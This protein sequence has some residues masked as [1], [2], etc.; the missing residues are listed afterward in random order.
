MGARYCFT[1]SLAVRRR[2]RSVP[3][4]SSSSSCS[5]SLAPGGASLAS[6]C[7]E[8][9]FGVSRRVGRGR[10]EDGVELCC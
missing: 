5:S 8:V 10:T 1:V 3:L 6:M 9:L 7:S 2:S 4:A